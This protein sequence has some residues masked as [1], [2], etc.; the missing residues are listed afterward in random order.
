MARPVEFNR[1][2]ALEAALKLFWRQ[3]YVS[4]SL[5]EL[6]DVMGIGR[7][8]FYAAFG[9]KGSLFVEVLELFSTRTRKLLVDAWEETQSLDAVGRFFY[10][11]LLE[12]PRY[13]AGRGCM[14][15]NTILELAVVD[16][17]IAAQAAQEL[18]RVEAVFEGCFAASQQAGA[19]PDGLS[20]RELAGHVMLLNQ[21]LRVASRK[22][23]ARK[24]LKNQIDTALSLMGLAAAA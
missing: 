8:S 12:V 4:T 11:T 23:V 6:L 14:M 20:P 19:Y 2:Q 21:G 3:G 7:S 5:A 16:A 17:E 9:D 10:A 13:R 15:V 24:I 18:A 22:N 1:D